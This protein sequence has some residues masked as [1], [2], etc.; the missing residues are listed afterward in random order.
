[1]PKP[2]DPEAVSPLASPELRPP[3]G[4]GALAW[5]YMLLIPIEEVSQD[6]N[7]I[8]VASEDDLETLQDLLCQHFSGVSILP[9]IKGWGLRD[10]EDPETIE[11]N[12]NIPFVVYATPVAASERYFV[13]L[14]EELQQSLDQGL[15]LVERQDVFLVAGGR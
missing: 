11:L 6:G 3:M 8:F 1:M 5:R 9:P 7:A 13:K 15:I 14:Q 4:I 2:F 12:K 10:P